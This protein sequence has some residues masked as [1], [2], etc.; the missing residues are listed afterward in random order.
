MILPLRHEV[1]PTGRITGRKPHIA[2]HHGTPPRVASQFS[3]AQFTGSLPNGSRPSHEG[4]S[5]WAATTVA[6]LLFSTP[7]MAPTRSESLRRASPLGA[8]LRRSPA[9]TCAA[10]AGLGPHGVRK[11]QLTLR[12]PSHHISAQRNSTRQPHCQTACGSGASARPA[13]VTPKRSSTP[14]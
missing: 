7:R 3:S 12:V 5:R 14:R 13:T 8:P 6:A 1:R 9:P 2:A 11:R 4:R 10:S